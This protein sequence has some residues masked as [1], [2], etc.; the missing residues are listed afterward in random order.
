MPLRPPACGL[1]DQR[2]MTVLIAR[3]IPVVA[4]R[5]DRVIRILDAQILDQVDVSPTESTEELLEHI[6][7][8]GP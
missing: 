2:G 8:Y 4:A 1:R 6:T 3:T 5:C 7:R